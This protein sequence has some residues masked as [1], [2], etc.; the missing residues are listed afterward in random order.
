MWGERLETRGTGARPPPSWGAPP[1]GAAPHHLPGP[2]WSSRGACGLA[3]RL[4]PCGF[5][6]SPPSVLCLTSLP[7]CELGFLRGA[8]LGCRRAG[9][10]ESGAGQHLGPVYTGLFPEPWA[11][12]AAGAVP[13]NLSWSSGHS[14]SA[15][16]ARVWLVEAPVSRPE[17]CSRPVC[18]EAGGSTR[19]SVESDCVNVGLT[20]AGP[21][22]SSWNMWSGPESDGFPVELFVKKEN[23]ASCFRF[24]QMTG[25]LS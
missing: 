17:G 19:A 2:P 20:P 14:A 12:A 11:P 7:C 25:E 3:P 6:E 16:A 4:A 10:V 1:E 18:A 9:Q 5:R 13:R 15:S 22:D 8:G 23:R 21:R 24:C